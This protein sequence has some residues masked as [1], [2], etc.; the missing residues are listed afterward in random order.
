MVPSASGAARASY[1][2]RCCST[3][4]R[5][6]KRRLTT[7]TWKWSPPPVRSSTETSSPGKAASKSSVRVL[8]AMREV[9]EQVGAGEHPGRLAA[10]RDDDRRA[11]PTQ[12]REHLVHRLVRLDRGERG[13]H[14]SRDFVVE[15]VRVAEDEIEQTTLLQRADHV[16]ERAG[17]VVPHHGQLRDPVLLHQVDRLP[18][19]LV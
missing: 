7:V 9:L 5:P 18:D 4:E 19:L 17:R 13:L 14:R 3:S 12:G 2:S 10:G 8:T 1:T 6:S 15:R 16:R 11:A